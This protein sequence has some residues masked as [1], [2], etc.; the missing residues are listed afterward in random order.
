[1]L[2]VAFT[3]VRIRKCLEGGVPRR[4]SRPSAHCSAGLASP[5]HQLTPTLG[6]RPDDSDRPDRDAIQPA[7]GN[8]Q[9]FEFCDLG[10]GYCGYSFLERCG[11]GWR[12]PARS[13]TYPKPSSQAQLLEAD[14]SASGSDNERAAVE[15]GQSAIDRLI[16]GLADTPRHRDCTTLT[17]VRLGISESE[18]DC[19]HSLCSR[20]RRWRTTDAARAGGRLRCAV[21][22][23]VV[24]FYE[25]IV[26]LDDGERRQTSL[27]N[28]PMLDSK[29][30]MHR[31]CAEHAEATPPER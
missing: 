19:H 15:G 12:A 27:L 6:Q 20:S 29:I 30:V 21:C 24:G 9:P 4:E 10:H 16:T 23:D 7:A 3:S 17:G 5:A 13:S 25:P 14:A 1:M 31:L 18:H 11:T 28:E 2:K 26:V 22:G 8:G